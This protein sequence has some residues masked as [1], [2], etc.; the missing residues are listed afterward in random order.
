MQNWQIETSAPDRCPKCGGI[1]IPRE[2]PFGSYLDC[3]ICGLHLSTDADT[4]GVQA[5]AE[6][7]LGPDTG[8]HPRTHRGQARYREIG[9]AIARE[10]LSEEQANERFGISRSTYYRIKRGGNVNE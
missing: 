2:D 1:L 7:G 10:D 9:E 3:T 6:D 8:W 5:A 4:D